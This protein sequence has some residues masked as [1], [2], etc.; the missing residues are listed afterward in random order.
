MYRTLASLFLL[1][2]LAG[3]RADDEAQASLLGYWECDSGDC[4]DEAVE[5]AE[6]DGERVYSS[7]LH[8]R[9]AASDGRWTLD[10]A[11]LD[12]QCCEGLE[13]HYT[14]VSLDEHRLE[15]READTA[16]AVVMTRRP[17]VGAAADT[18]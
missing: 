4:P 9:P 3:A 16:G 7:W 13:Y 14:V 2:A 11:N 12:I 1:L 17:G 15:L 6:R 8:D 5:V 18:P 10:G